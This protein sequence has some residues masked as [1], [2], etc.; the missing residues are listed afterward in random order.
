[1]GIE[2]PLPRTDQHFRMDRIQ[3]SPLL[4][5][6]SLD[7]P[8]GEAAGPVLALPSFKPCGWRNHL[9]LAILEAL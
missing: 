3:M 4:M 2:G 9:M 5:A 7:R 1:M 8:G 6:E